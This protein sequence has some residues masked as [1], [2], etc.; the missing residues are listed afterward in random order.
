[1]QLNFDFTSLW[2]DGLYKQITGF[3]LLGLCLVSALLSMRKRIPKIEIGHFS[4]WRLFHVSAG[5]IALLL[6][7]IHT[8]FSLGDNLNQWLMVNFLGLG[9]I[10][11]IAGIIIHYEGKLLGGATVRQVRRYSTL[12]HILLLWPLPILPRSIPRSET[13]EA[14]ARSIMRSNLLF[15]LGKIKQT[16]Q[17]YSAMIN[18]WCAADLRLA[19]I[20]L[21]RFAG[22]LTPDPMGL[23]G[24]IPWDQHRLHVLRRRE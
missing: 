4:I 21:A 20:N 16:P 3:S 22:S 24:W 12:A 15:A 14:T 17:R 18:P 9:A 7:I 2:T 6:L 10:G 19:N 13:G 11:A 23:Q 8:G 5:L 1:V